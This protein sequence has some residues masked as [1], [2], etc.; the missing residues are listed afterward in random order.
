MNY[1]LCTFKTRH[2]LSVLTVDTRYWYLEYDL[3]R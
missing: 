1:Q 3:I 2:K